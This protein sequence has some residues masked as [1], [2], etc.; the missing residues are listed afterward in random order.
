LPD[1]RRKNEKVDDS[2]DNRPNIIENEKNS[3]I[4]EKDG[5]LTPNSQRRR[6]Q[7]RQQNGKDREHKSDDELS[8]EAT[9]AAGSAGRRGKFIW[10]TRCTLK[11]C[12]ASGE[13]AD[14]KAN[15]LLAEL[16]I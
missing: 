12:F 11:L 5:Y 13:N 6:Q 4:A 8:D 7:K 1:E 16:I 3:E 15:Q 9:V 14:E 10:D 2:A